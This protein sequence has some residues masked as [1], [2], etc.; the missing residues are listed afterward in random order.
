MVAD[1]VN[2]VRGRDNAT[3][4]MTPSFV[5]GVDDKSRLNTGWHIRLCA[6]SGYEDLQWCIDTG[7]QVSVM[8]ENVYQPSFGLLLETDRILTGAGEAKLDTVGYVR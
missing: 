1:H 8:P 5:G 4:A 2:E 6:G 7:A 3:P